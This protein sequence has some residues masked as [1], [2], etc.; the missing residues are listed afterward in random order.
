[1]D[2][3]YYERGQRWLNLL[4]PAALRS[5]FAPG[6]YE[7]LLAQK[8]TLC[9]FLRNIRKDIARTYPAHPYFS[10]P[11]GGKEALFR[12]LVAYS[13]YD[14][15]IGYSQGMAFI[16]GLLLLHVE[17]EEDAFW[18]LVRVMYSP[19][20]NLRAFYTDDC[21]TLKG[22]IRL[23]EALVNRELPEL[24][25]HFAREGISANMY[26]TQWIVTV[27]TY[28]IP[29]SF[30]VRVWDR[31][32]NVGHKTVY[33][34]GIAV[35]RHHAAALLEMGFEQAVLFLGQLDEGQLPVRLAEEEECEKVHI[36]R[37]DEREIDRILRLSG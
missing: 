30:A 10:P 11:Y 28:R 35:L 18:C 9:P 36:T 12:V 5:R 13:I 19:E 33:Q 24:G 37:Q 20:Y 26:A 6:L 16:A 1:M 8:D 21:K 27:W 31:F 15:D 7:K 2:S 17:S 4:N 25:Q 3:E 14:I 22:S 23:F 29:L 34:T 32:L